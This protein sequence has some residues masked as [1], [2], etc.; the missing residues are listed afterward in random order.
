MQNGAALLLAAQPGFDPYSGHTDTGW[1]GSKLAHSVAHAVNSVAKQAQKGVNTI[2]HAAVKVY[3]TPADVVGKVLPTVLNKVLP[4]KLGKYAE[5]VVAPQN[6]VR[7]YAIGMMANTARGAINT[8]QHPNINN[9]IATAQQSMKATG[10]LGMVGAGALG[11][12]GA[13]LQGKN[14]ES[15]AWAAAEGAAPDGIAQAIGAAEKIRHG[16]SIID[17]ALKQAQTSFLPGT[18]EL[19]GFNSAVAALKNQA[20][21]AGLGEIRRTLGNEGA[22]RAFDVAIGTVSKV[23]KA[24]SGALG[25]RANSIPNIVTQRARTAISATNPQISHVLKAFQ[26]NPSLMAV[27]PHILASQ[28]GTHVSAINDAVNRSS[29][30]PML[31]WRSMSPHAVNFIRRYAPQSPLMALRHLHTDTAGLDQTGMKYIVEKGDGPWAIAQKLTGNGNRWTELKAVN[32]D[33]N[34][35]I[36]KNVWVGEVLNLPLSWQKPAVVAKPPT[37]ALPAAPPPTIGPV[38]STGVPVLATP[39]IDITPSI[40]QGKSILVAWSKTDG[41]NQAGLPDYGLNVSDLSTSMGPRDILELASFQ[42]WN[43]KTLGSSLNTS[44]ALDPATLSALQAWAESRASAAL[45]AS[46]TAGGA[47]PSLPVPVVIPEIT[48]GGT[49]PPALPPGVPA[50]PSGVSPLPTVAPTNQPTTPGKV[51]AQ[52]SGSSLGPIAMGAVVG[53]LLFGVPGALAGAAGGAAIS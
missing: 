25:T 20:S 24:N 21:M 29:K 23:V 5:Y 28:F 15:I 52:K 49:A 47:A 34:P 38:P 17:V 53:G 39:S 37:S 2:E 51:A 31:P 22:K 18:L 4:G 14:L 19:V 43:N 46:V 10:P 13:G 12:M 41:V 11:A 27:D 33:K 8:V 16:G 32:Q 48:I 45:P 7:K 26:R 36:E 50:L 42:N 40:I 35:K 1:F 44:G 6:I 9:L 3:S 30:V